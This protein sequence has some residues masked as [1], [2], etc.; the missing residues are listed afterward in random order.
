M[1]AVAS[2]ISSVVK[3]QSLFDRWRQLDS[4]RLGNGTEL[5]GWMPSDESGT[6]MHCV[7]HGLAPDRI[8]DLERQLVSPLQND[9]RALYRWCNG[10]TLF[11]GAF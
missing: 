1:P 6:W 10:M 9:L 3:I 4:K 2:A 8:D 7:F 11:T 5:I